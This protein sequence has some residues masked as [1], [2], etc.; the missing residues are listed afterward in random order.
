MLSGQ[1]IPGYRQNALPLFSYIP[2]L[3]RRLF[4]KR[5]EPGLS[6]PGKFCRPTAPW[7]L[8]DPN[9][10]QARKNKSCLSQERIYRAF[11]SDRPPPALRDAGRGRLYPAAVQYHLH[12]HSLFQS[13][14][15]RTGGDRHKGQRIYPGALSGEYFPLRCGRILRDKQQL[16]ER[17]I[18]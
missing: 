11:P 6:C 17:S 16:S 5:P 1:D 13:A 15:R 12:T 14:C 8:P 2:G 3:I 7:L 9:H 18:S 4:F 10:L